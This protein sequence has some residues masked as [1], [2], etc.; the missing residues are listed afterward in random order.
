MT[1]IDGVSIQNDVQMPPRHNSNSFF[2]PMWAMEVGQSFEFHRDVI[3]RVRPMGR[4]LQKYG[5][6]YTIRHISGEMYRVWRT[7]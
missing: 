5:R 4:R 3:N 2:A 6:E 7:R 1:E